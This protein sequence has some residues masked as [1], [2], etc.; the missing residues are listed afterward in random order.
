MH[1]IKGFFGPSG[2]CALS[3]EVIIGFLN[4]AWG[5][6][7]KSVGWCERYKGEYGQ[8][9]KRQVVIYFGSN[10]LCSYNNEYHIII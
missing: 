10:N 9:H 5:L 8:R 2:L 6:T 4:C 1:T 7:Q 3:E